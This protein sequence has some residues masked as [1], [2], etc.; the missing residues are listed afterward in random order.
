MGRVVTPT[1]I[2]I[3]NPYDMKSLWFEFRRD[4]CTGLEFQDFKLRGLQFH[5][6]KQLKNEHPN[7]RPCNFECVQII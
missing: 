6:I 7:S 4:I 1:S 3:L 2:T 5:F